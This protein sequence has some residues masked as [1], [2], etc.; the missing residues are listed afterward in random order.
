FQAAQAVRQGDQRVSGDPVEAGGHGDRDRGGETA[1]VSRGV[2]E[3]CWLEE[4]AGV[5]HGEALCQRSCGALR[6]RG[7]ADSR[8]IWVYQ[9]LSSGEV[10]SRREAV[11]HW[12][13]DE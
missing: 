6:E 1:D 4:Y 13:R 2:A 8:R 7:R 12:R 9:R 3:R 10:L 5:V 11:H